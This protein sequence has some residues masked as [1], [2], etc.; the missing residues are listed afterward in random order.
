MKTVEQIILFDGV[1]NLCNTSVQ[2]VLKRDT[3]ATFKFASLQSNA[4]QKLL[5][6]FKLPL[7]EFNS[8][9]YIDDGKLYTRS[10][11]A[12]RVAKE[13]NFPWKL[14]FGF[15]VVPS[16]I[17][18]FVYDIIAKNRYKWFGKRESCMIPTAELKQ[19]FLE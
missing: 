14:M 12:L 8:F 13:L 5:A 6:D 4:G 2:F 19:R 15:I 1:C 9:I 18:N 7:D 3:K 16:F 17:R 10:S 11:A